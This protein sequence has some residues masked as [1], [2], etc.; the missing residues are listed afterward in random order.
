MDF[1]TRLDAVRSEWNVLEHPFYRRWSAGDLSR[2]ELAEY[3]GQYR[4]AVVALAEGS[5]RAARMT[6]GAALGSHLDEHAAEEASHVELWDRF[7]E[8]MGGRVDAPASDETE[9]CASAWRGSDERSLAAA[10]VGL[11]AIEAA[12]PAIAETKRAGLTELYGFE[13]GPATEYFDLHA[14]LDVHHARAHRE[15]IEPLLADADEQ[16]LLDAAREVLSGNWKLLDGVE[17]ARG[18]S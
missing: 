12:Q 9:A 10:L 1:W 4:H 17:H 18:S 8:A 3:A 14:E 11:Y 2:D 6:G 13:P 15:T 5:A 16:E 7:A